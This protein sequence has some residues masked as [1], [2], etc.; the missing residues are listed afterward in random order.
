M[1][2][3]WKE[4]KSN[5]VSRGK[6]IELESLSVAKVDDEVGWRSTVLGGEGGGVEVNGD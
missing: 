5:L 2:I 6:Y 3:N 4:I 1:S